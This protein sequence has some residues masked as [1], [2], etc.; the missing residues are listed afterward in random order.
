MSL[1]PCLLPLLFKFPYHILR[2]QVQVNL[3][4]GEPIMPYPPLQG[5]EG[6]TFLHGCNRKGV[7]QHMGGHRAVDAGFVG[8]AFEDTLNGAGRHADGVMDCKVAVDEW[9]YPVGEGN[10]AALG[11]CAVD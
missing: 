9:A 8:N 4:S 10:D 1:S 7:S 5:R 2:R 6:D 3:S 11:L